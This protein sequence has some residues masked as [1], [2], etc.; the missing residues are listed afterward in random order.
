[1]RIVTEEIKSGDDD[2]PISVFGDL[3]NPQPSKVELKRMQEELEKL[4]DD[5]KN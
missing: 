3:D 1:M 5:I 2:G 4:N